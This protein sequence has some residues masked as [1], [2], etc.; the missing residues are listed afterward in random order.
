MPRLLLL[1]LLRDMVG[2]RGLLAELI[3]GSSAGFAPWDEV[4]RRVPGVSILGT[5]CAGPSEGQSVVRQAR[6]GTAAAL[7]CP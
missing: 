4:Q 6:Q 7:F 5:A 1:L 2:F 3:V